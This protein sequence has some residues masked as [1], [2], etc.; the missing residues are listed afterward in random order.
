MTFGA[1]VMAIS[2]RLVA[3]IVRKGRMVA[4]VLAGPAFLRHDGD[5]YTSNNV[6]P[7]HDQGAVFGLGVRARLAPSTA[8]RV[9]LEDYAYTIGLTNSY[10]NFAYRTMQNDVVL[11]VGL[12][13]TLWTAPVTK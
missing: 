3:S 7:T 6:A 2:L 8:V 9:E 4:Y 1:D 12:S 10:G 13:V 5:V 11:S